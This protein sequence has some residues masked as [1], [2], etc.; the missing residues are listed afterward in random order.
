M[1]TVRGGLEKKKKKSEAAAAAQAAASALACDV[2]GTERPMGARHFRDVT[3]HVTSGRNSS[4]ER[5]FNGTD[6]GGGGK[7][8]SVGFFSYRVGYSSAVV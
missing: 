5:S 2:N 3:A 6:A 4:L 1:K 7:V 8:G